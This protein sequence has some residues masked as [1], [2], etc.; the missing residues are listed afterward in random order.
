MSF[1]NDPRLTI[2]FST[3]NA[4]NDDLIAAFICSEINTCFRLKNAKLIFKIMAKPILIRILKKFVNSY[5]H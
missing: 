4:L 5:T 3:S 1:Q 2:V